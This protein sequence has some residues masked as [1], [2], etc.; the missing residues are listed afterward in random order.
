MAALAGIAR[1]NRPAG[2]EGF[3]ARC[4]APAGLS[5]LVSEKIGKFG[6]FAVA[7]TVA[8]AAGAEALLATMTEDSRAGAGTA[9][10]AAPGKGRG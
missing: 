4:G 1:K 5:R 2:A 9:A 10:L 7:E 6:T 3:E 8:G